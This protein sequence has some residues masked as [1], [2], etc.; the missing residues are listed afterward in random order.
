[1]RDAGERW[2]GA[3]ALARFFHCGTGTIRAAVKRTPELRAWQ[4]ASGLVA[5]RH[6]KWPAI[7][8][9]LLAIRRGGAAWP[10]VAAL[11]DRLD[12]TKS[13]IWGAVYHSPELKAWVHTTEL[14]G[15]R[16]KWEEA[17]DQVLKIFRTGEE[18]P[19]PV[20]L[21][22]RLHRGIQSIKTAVERDPELTAWR[23]KKRRVSVD[24]ARSDWQQDS[25]LEG[26]ACAHCGSSDCPV[27]RSV[28][29]PGGIRR[30]RICRACSLRFTT[31]EA[32][33]PKPNFSRA[34]S[35]E[36]RKDK[37]AFPAKRKRAGKRRRPP[38]EVKMRPLTVR[39]IEALQMVLECNGNFAEAARRLKVVPKTIREHYFN[40]LKKL[41]ATG[42]LAVD[43]K[44][45]KAAG[46]LPT[47]RRGQ[48]DA[49]RDH[50]GV[51]RPGRKFRLGDRRGEA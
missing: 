28:K 11:A 46:E 7:Q 26:L 32:M 43:R 8:A 6:A 45:K 49:Y 16:P 9:E 4:E 20:A 36:Q 41:S 17:R 33:A 14:R 15:G 1:M 12:L 37:P 40:A 23:A 44:M 19:G 27:I 48:L 13:Q 3:A 38:F 50:D 34:S 31:I 39:Q 21:A 5:R 42:L 30:R 18:Y 25:G 51:D 22:R 29:R 24:L 10:G 35:A 47:D 2:R